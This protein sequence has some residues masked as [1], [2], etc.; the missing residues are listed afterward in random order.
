[1]SERARNNDNIAS[2]YSSSGEVF[3]L[4]SLVHDGVLPL[5][6]VLILSRLPLI[7]VLSDHLLDTDTDTEKERGN[8]NFP[9]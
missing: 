3:A 9:L 6:A 8:L 2:A 7:H 4:S 5:T 1:M